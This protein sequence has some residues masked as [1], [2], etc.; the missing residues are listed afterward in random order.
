MLFTPWPIGIA[1]VAPH[2]GRLAD[3]YQP[4]L[5]STAGLVVFT[6]GLALLALLPNHPQAL[7][8]AWRALVCGV[9]FG[10]FQSPNNRE[11]LANTSRERSGNAS[12]VLAIMRTFGQCLGAAL[13]AIILSAYAAQ[14]LADSKTLMSAMQDAQAIRLSLGLAAIATALATI[15]SGCRIRKVHD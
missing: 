13:V 4:A 1:L 14:V 12:G 6:I 5:L 3:R 9:G 10:F 8:I 7:D 11:M 15:I 2:A